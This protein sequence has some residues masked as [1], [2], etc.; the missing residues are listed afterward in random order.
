MSER[1]RVAR[2]EGVEAQ[3]YGMREGREEKV[4][5]GALK[6]LMGRTQARM[7]RTEVGG[8]G[9]GH[10]LTQAISFAGRGSGLGALPALPLAELLYDIDDLA[11]ARALIADYLPSARVFSLADELSSGYVVAGLSL[12]HFS[13][14][15]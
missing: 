13:E 11:G 8:Q 4:D 7:R 12:I 5:N 2:S 14:P 3:A 15:T 9:L 1:C 10:G 6:G